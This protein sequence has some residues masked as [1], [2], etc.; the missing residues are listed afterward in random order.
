MLI[1]G[2]LWAYDCSRY[3]LS[4]FILAMAAM[5]RPDG[6][7]A[8]VALGVV[9]LVRR[10]PVPWRAV[11]VYVGLVG[12]FYTGLWI[13]FGSP[14]PVTL[15]A[16]QQQGQMAASMRFGSGFRSNWEDHPEKCTDHQVDKKPHSRGA[17][18]AP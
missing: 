2:G 5:V 18:A 17:R 4:A 10:Q 8:A 16:K 6:V 14:L 13:Y 7:M 3:D 1:L 9:H 15:L 12:A 11:I